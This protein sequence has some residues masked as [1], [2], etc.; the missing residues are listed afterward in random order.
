MGKGGAVRSQISSRVRS[1]AVARVGNIV[2]VS[3]KF[4]WRGCGLTQR[5]NSGLGNIRKWAYLELGKH[6]PH[7]C[8][9]YTCSRG[10]VALP[11]VTIVPLFRQLAPFLSWLLTSRLR[12]KLTRSLKATH[13]QE[14]MHSRLVFFTSQIVCG[15]PGHGMNQ[16]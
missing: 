12:V 9:R 2:T 4:R 10:V 1:Q 11:P 3:S 8:S 6:L 14:G 16:R 5:L 13:K 7:S 15:S